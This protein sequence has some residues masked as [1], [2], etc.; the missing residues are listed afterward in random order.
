MWNHSALAA[1]RR[2]LE[3]GEHMQI[4]RSIENYPELIHPTFLLALR[5]FYENWES[6]TNGDWP[7]YRFV[8]AYELLEFIER[9]GIDEGISLHLAKRALSQRP[10]DRNQ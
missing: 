3:T 2:A 7:S 5:A 6:A 4:R 1:L 9:D 10:T 8:G